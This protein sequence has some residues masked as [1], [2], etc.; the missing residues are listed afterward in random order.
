M[1]IQLNTDA[2]IDGTKALEAQVH[3][4]VQGALEHLSQHITRVEVHLSDTNGDTKGG[5]ADMRCLLEARPAGHQPVA[6]SHQAATVDEALD[7]AADKLKR[8]L[9]S[10]LGR[11][12][13]Y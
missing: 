5:P 1:F 13:K 12:A 11:L 4:V 10:L 8:S 6:V 9:D 2:S 7:G 3:A